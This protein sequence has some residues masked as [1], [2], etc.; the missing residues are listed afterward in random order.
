M[1]TTPTGKSE[2][3]R[4]P[5]LE[6]SQKE[7][8][9]VAVSDKSFQLIEKPTSPTDAKIVSDGDLLQVTDEGI[10]SKPDIGTENVL[11][12]S[13]DHIDRNIEH[14]VSDQTGEPQPTEIPL[15]PTSETKQ[16]HGD[17]NINIAEAAEANVSVPLPL[18]ETGSTV[19]QRIRSPIAQEL[20]E[21]L[22]T[23]AASDIPEP[24]SLSAQPG[25]PEKPTAADSN[26][27]P[28]GENDSDAKLPKEKKHF[29]PKPANKQDTNRLRFAQEHPALLTREQMSRFIDPKFLTRFN[30][31]LRGPPS[32]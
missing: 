23:A 17:T 30:P 21:V 19:P 25:Q 9:P 8:C 15:S 2:S 31:D 4:S 28:V 7:A 32:D 11:N 24:I 5:P 16:E 26:A 10:P 12:N 13:S 20:E 29:V 22:K 27:G 3:K 6:D 14:A 18:S 1:D